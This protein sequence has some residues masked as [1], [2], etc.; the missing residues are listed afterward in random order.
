MRA[1]GSVAF[2]KGWPR[3]LDAYL[4]GRPEAAAALAEA[5]AM[6]DP[7]RRLE[8][9][10]VFSGLTVPMVWD[11]GPAELEAERADARASTRP[12]QVGWSTSASSGQP[13]VRAGGGAPAG[14]A[15][16]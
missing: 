8:E 3:V 6:R 12:S 16:G 14:K 4:E 15:G 1:L 7:K 5:Q 2:E 11:R 13:V 9:G 10:M